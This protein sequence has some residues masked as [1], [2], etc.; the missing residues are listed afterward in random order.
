M[1]GEP[2]PVFLLASPSAALAATLSSI[3]DNG[4]VRLHAVTSGEAAIAAVL[5]PAPPC[6]VLLDSRLPGMDLPQL[7]AALRAGSD[8]RR[9]PLVLISEN[10]PPDWSDRLH[11]GVI[12]DL[13]PLSMPDFHWR[14][15]IDSVL[16]AFRHTRELEHL[17][18]TTHRDTDSLT[19]LLNRA[20]LLAMLFRETDRVQRMNTS[21]TLMLFALDDFAHWRARLGGPGCDELLKEVVVRVQRLLRSYDLFGRVA[22]AGFALGLPGCTPV[23]AVSLAERIR[24]EVF[25]TPFRVA[26]TAVRATANFGIAPS[27]GRSPLVV[28]REAEQALEAARAAGPDAIRTSRMCP[29]IPIAPAEF[30][31]RLP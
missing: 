20:A 23:N 19:G 29:E 1:T 26:G 15:R 6:L 14:V 4:G 21:L 3:L 9:F 16:R 13:F 5:R 24:T 7:L 28:L 11:E 2:Q 12:D 27:H 31:S 18:E 30:L 17:R 8:E 10:Q 22:G 25:C